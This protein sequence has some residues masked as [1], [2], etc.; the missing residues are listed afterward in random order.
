MPTVFLRV[1]IGLYMHAHA[2]TH[3][4]ALI[5]TYTVLTHIHKEH[6]KMTSEVG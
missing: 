2:H 5:L 4:H 1:V 6:I 3:T